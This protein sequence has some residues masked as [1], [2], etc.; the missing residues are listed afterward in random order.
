[1]DQGIIMVAKLYYQQHSMK[2]VIDAQRKV[3]NLIEFLK[4]VPLDNVIHWLAAAWNEVRLDTISKCWNN[5]MPVKKQDAATL[6][7]E[8]SD[9]IS[10]INLDHY[11][12]LLVGSESVESSRIYENS[13][14]VQELLVLIRKEDGYE[15]IDGMTVVDWM[16][17]T[18]LGKSITKN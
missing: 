14:S 4:T 10:F 2:A 8:I 5:L 9:S 18:N 16:N 12:E 6:T 3:L 1:M 11:S 13:P 7:E 17:K 15:N